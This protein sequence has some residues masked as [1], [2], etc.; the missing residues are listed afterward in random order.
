MMD[1]K[2]L[3]AEKPDCIV[4]IPNL[5]AKAQQMYAD[6]SE[7]GFKNIAD[8]CGVSA[9]YLRSILNSQG[10]SL[11]GKNPR[12]SI[13][14]KDTKELESKWEKGFD[15]SGR[16]TKSVEE[17]HKTPP[18]KIVTINIPDQYLDC[19]E[20]MVNLGFFPSRSEAVREALKGFL[21]NESTLNSDL[22]KT[23]F[24]LLKQ[25]QMRSLMH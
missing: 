9:K 22:D 3:P 16:P 23:A 25:K 15:K 5:I 20:S 7:Q 4:N 12:N 6:D 21:S 14:Q 2:S 13:S 24:G 18:M 1:V 11:T 10:I 19:I 17:K 8:R